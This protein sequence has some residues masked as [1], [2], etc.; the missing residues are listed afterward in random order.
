MARERESE[1]DSLTK[2]SKA[3]S[4]LSV[5]NHPTRLGCAPGVS[6]SLSTRRIDFQLITWLY[7][8]F[9]TSNLKSDV[10]RVH[11]S[12]ESAGAKRIFSHDDKGFFL[13]SDFFLSDVCLCQWCIDMCPKR[14]NIDENN[15][16]LQ[17]RTVKPCIESINWADV[18]FCKDCCS[19][20]ESV[21]IT[22]KWWKWKWPIWTNYS[23]GK[24]PW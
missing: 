20:T 11:T 18:C 22:D 14:K 10:E 15:R 12:T 24:W 5:L 17:W 3:F 4:S 8:E 1:L 23:G 19:L 7:D 13:K 9:L 21:E 2:E 6:H 16:L